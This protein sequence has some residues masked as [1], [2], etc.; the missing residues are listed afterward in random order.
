[1]KTFKALFEEITALL[2]GGNVKIGEH[3]AEPIKLTADTRKKSA[4]DVRES[5]SSLHDSFHKETGH[6]LFG[7]DKKALNTGSAYSGSTAHFMGPVSDKEFVAHKPNVG[8]IDVQVHK[9]HFDQLVDHL[10][11]HKEAGTSFGPYK[12][13]GIKKAGAE[14]HVLMQHN[15]GSV[16][17]FDFEK[18][19]YQDNEPSKFDQLAHSSDWNDI[20]SGIKG[21]HHKLLLNAA[22]GN[23]HKFSILYGVGHRDGDPQWKNTPGEMSSS[24]FGDKADPK[25]MSSFKGVAQSIKDHIP[26]EQ[27]QDIYNKFKNDLSRHKKIN[28]SAALEHLRNTL[29]VKDE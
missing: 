18:T 7:E 2:E 10:N 12:V 27:H 15:N 28:H 22:G 29:N 24:L 26:A 11:K 20:K 3:E 25:N 21:M 23:K 16:H 8:D 4:D 9:D 5:L 1:M 6:H 17:Q 14:A 13:L 19:N